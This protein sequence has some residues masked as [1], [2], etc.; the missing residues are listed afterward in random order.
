MFWYNC[1]LLTKL[2]FQLYCHLEKKGSF[3]NDRQF[4]KYLQQVM[5]LS[6]LN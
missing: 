5:Q 3:M 4:V 1:K 6:L 2:Y